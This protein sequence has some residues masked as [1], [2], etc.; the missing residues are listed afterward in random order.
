V[1][2]VVPDAVGE[3]EGWKAL[4]VYGP[5]AIP[6]LFSPAA[7][8]KAMKLVWPTGGWFHARC[9]K[10]HEGEGGLPG[11]RC[12]CGIYALGSW[13][14]VIRDGYVDFKHVVIAR[15]GLAGKVI[16]GKRGLRAERA[17]VVELVVPYEMWRLAQPLAAAYDVETRIGNIHWGGGKT[18][19]T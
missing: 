16:P 2:A 5:V 4:A 13:Q 11:A 15:L 10:K 6:R 1:T 19:W 17:R 3:V 14:L 18:P 8:G 7:G 9:S 12:S